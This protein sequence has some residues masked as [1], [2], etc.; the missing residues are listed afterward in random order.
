MFLFRLAV[1]VSYLPDASS[2]EEFAWLAVA[3]R[4][5]ACGAV[6]LILDVEA[7]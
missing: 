5:D 6:S 4:C 3:G 2:G 1:A 7:D